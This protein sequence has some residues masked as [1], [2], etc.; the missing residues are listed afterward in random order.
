LKKPYYC[1]VTLSMKNL[2]G[3]TPNSLY[4]AQAGNEEAT[5][6]RI[7][8][9]NP[10][11]S[12]SSGCR[13]EGRHRSTDPTWRVPRITVDVCAARPNPSGNR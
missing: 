7:P 13:L 9:H 4:G 12:K 10:K 2:F 1:R 6:G 3:L 5:E 11:G 8:L